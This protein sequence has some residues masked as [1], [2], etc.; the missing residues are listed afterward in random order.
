LAGRGATPDTLL[1]QLAR[2]GEQLARVIGPALAPLCGG[3]EPLVQVVEPEKIVESAL[4][5]RIGALAANAL[6]AHGRG[7]DRTVLSID[8]RAV[9][10]QL[11]RAFGGNGAVADDLP[12]AL[13]RSA[14]IF[15]QRLEA[16]AATALGQALGL[17]ESEAPRICARDGQY[18][19]LAPFPAGCELAVLAL[20]VRE[21]GNDPWRILFATRLAA[22]PRLL[23]AG[24]RTSARA[25]DAP[26]SPL[27]E[28]FAGMALPLE[29]RLV[30]MPIKLSK[31]A[32]LA[33]GMTIPI[34]LDRQVPL[35]VGTSVVARGTVG[36]MDDRIALQITTTHLSR[37]ETR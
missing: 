15:A 21:G 22:L 37:Q 17:P 16:I 18:R 20:E 29:A 19:M 23:G 26:A 27:D 11:D 4:A 34:A 12:R 10:A 24:S 35:R 6:L 8:A 28:P 7:G 5:A 3:A 2:M 9:M 32:G 14:D 33:P 25:H 31:L 13:P 36:E 1:A 30:D